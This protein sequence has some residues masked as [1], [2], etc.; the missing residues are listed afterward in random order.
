MTLM[1]KHEIDKYLAEQVMSFEVNKDE[2]PPFIGVWVGKRPD[3]EWWLWSPTGSLDQA[4][5][6]AKEII[7]D[8]TWTF[9]LHM[10]GNK[11]YCSFSRSINSFRNQKI[12]GCDLAEAISRAA[13]Q[14]HKE[15][16]KGEDT[17]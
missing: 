10:K 16:L 14:A 11:I 6:V 5:M 12:Y 4:F 17:P 7:K 15:L 3:Q 13:V 9:N 8:G 1:T 2:P